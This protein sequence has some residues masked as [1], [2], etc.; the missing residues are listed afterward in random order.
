MSSYESIFLPQY[1]YQE[2][3]KAI[4]DDQG[5][6]RLETHPTVYAV[7]SNASA[8]ALLDL[9]FACSLA[10]TD[11]DAK[12]TIFM[13]LL[14]TYAN[15]MIKGVYGKVPDGHL[16]MKVL[17]EH[18][19]KVLSDLREEMIRLANSD[20]PTLAPDAYSKF[21]L[22]WDLPAPDDNLISTTGIFC[23]S[24]KSLYAHFSLVVF[25]AG[26]QITDSN[27]SAITTARP[28]AL[29]EKFKI[30]GVDILNGPLRISDYSHTQVNQAWLE[31]SS[32]T[33]TCFEFFS[34]YSHGK[35]TMLL[36]IVNT[37][38]MLLRYAMM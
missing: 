20:D 32:F 23:R 6:A 34:A 7:P 15:T 29:I 12:L 8:D 27:R 22:T 31:M 38:V 33:H 13:N 35:S 16:I 17:K 24:P 10:F 19:M 9:A 14:A 2:D 30:M 5:A 28:R 36:D 1:L 4:R 18:E 26:K 3:A 25:L 21:R 37:N 11:Q